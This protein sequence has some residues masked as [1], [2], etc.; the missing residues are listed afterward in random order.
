MS[1]APPRFFITVHPGGLLSGGCCSPVQERSAAK[2][3][4]W[5]Q[6]PSA[7]PGSAAGWGGGRRRA[8]KQ[9][10][11]LNSARAKHNISSTWSDVHGTLTHSLSLSLSLRDGCSL[12][13]FNIRNLTEKSKSINPNVSRGGRTWRR[14]S[15]GGGGG[16][17]LGLF[18][19]N[20]FSAKFKF[21][22]TLQPNMPVG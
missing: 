1:G 3:P 9:A 14:L 20:Y 8:G 6:D 4:A 21:G 16:V 22:Q 12:E 5:G 15:R 13:G 17:T 18:C 2:S 19:S 10:E 7:P 11:E